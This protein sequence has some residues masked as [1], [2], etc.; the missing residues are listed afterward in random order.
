MREFDLVVE[1]EAYRVT[2]PPI[3]AAMAE[4]WAAQ[5]WPCCAE[6]TDR[7]L[8]A[9]CSAPTASPPPWFVYRITLPSATALR[10]FEPR[11]AT[12]WRF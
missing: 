3:V 1:G 12:R 8:T 9:E 7:E 5:G 11:R 2:D 4:C 6:E 10:I